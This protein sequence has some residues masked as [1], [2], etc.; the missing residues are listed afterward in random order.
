MDREQA[1]EI[2]SKFDNSTKLFSLAGMRTWARLVEFFD[3]DTCKVVF[4]FANNDVHKVIV[5]VNGID[6]P[7]MKSKD[8]TVQTWAVK[9]RNRMLSLVAPDVFEVDGN[10]SKKDITKLLKENICIIWLDTLAFDRYGRLLA[11]LYFSPTDTKSLQA[12]CI[13]EGYAKAYS[14]KTKKQWVQADC[15]TPALSAPPRVDP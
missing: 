5:R 2:L 8:P 12:I 14:G 13:E 4:P 7:E 11:D 1:I 9:A 3:G 10:Y 15:V 6:T